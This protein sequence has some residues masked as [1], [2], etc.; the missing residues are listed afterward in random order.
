MK[1]S[2]TREDLSY[3]KIPLYILFSYFGEALVRQKTLS[4]F[5]LFFYLLH[6]DA[7]PGAN[8]TEYRPSYSN[9]YGRDITRVDDP[10]GVSTMRSDFTLAASSADS[11]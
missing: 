3:R 7:Y 8:I 5:H 6:K 11:R 4:F 10:T 9:I 2:C 1:K